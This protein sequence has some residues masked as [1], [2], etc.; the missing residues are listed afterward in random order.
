MLYNNNP[1]QKL[2]GYRKFKLL[3]QHPDMG[4]QVSTQKKKC[5][6]TYGVPSKP[7]PTGYSLKLRSRR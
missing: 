4:H 1:T 2:R 7:A 3:L 5:F 6:M